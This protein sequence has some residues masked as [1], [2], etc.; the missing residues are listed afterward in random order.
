MRVTLTSTGTPGS[1]AVGT[2][3]IVPSAAVGTGLSNYAITYV[4][5]T[6]MITRANQTIT[7]AALANRTLAQSPFTVSATASSGLIVTFTT[8]GACTSSG[9]NGHT[10]TLIGLG[11]CTVVA[12]QAGNV[13]YSPAPTVIQ[14]F[15]VKRK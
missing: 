15:T 7:F 4:A 1:A 12:S 13:S 10:I 8:M 6:L 5:G 14:S 11:T 9:L 2:Y 3:P